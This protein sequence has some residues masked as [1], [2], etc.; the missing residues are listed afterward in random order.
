LLKRT[1]SGI[2]LTL[3]LTSMLTLAFNI[4]PVKTE[5]STII[6]P[7]N[8]PTI[9]EA[10]NNANEGDII[11]VRNGTY[12]ENLVVNKTVTLTGESKTT[13]KI[14]W[15]GI[16]ILITQDSVSLGGFTIQNIN[17]TYAAAILLQN[18][19]QCKI[20][21][22]DIP[23]YSEGITLEGANNNSIVEN[24]IHKASSYAPDWGINV[25]GSNYNNIVG[26]N[27][28]GNWYGIKLLHNSSGNSIIGNSMTENFGHGLSI[29]NSSSNTI[30]ENNITDTW[31][32]GLS[33]TYSSHNSIVENNIMRNYIGIYLRYSSY[34]SIY[35]NNFMNNGHQ[36]DVQGSTSEL[37]DGYPSGGNYWSDY[38]G[39]DE[40]WGA[41]QNLTG[42]DG[43]GDTPY[44]IDANNTDH[45]PLMGEFS[46]FNVTHGV[47]VQVV[48]NSTVSDFEFNGTAI[49]FNV[50]GVNGS[51]GFCNARIPT[52]LF[53]GTLTVFVNG[54]QVKYS[55]V[56]SSNSS[57]SYL[58]FTY[59]L[60]TEQ[61]AIVPEFPDSLILAMFM[62][63][64][65]LTIAIYKK[66]HS[67]S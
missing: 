35:H 20:F 5:P 50:S 46:D 23:N 65:L 30:I 6:V 26:N 37:D 15:K 44:V 52:A 4:Q 17:E 16:P 41:Y 3:L 14:E 19:S 49:L 61:V 38:T 43:I 2:M 36:T 33:V 45:Y 57:I 63:A 58:Y 13:T 53:N 12:Y 51:M 66:R 56:P 28:T 60:S 22:N 54:T 47:D 55:S 27:L 21:G 18:V 25:A 8:Y 31:Y 48:S 62:L 39:V 40:Y 42:S 34:D 67:R 64:T 29:Y 7:D 11:F 24:N 9:Q 1:V 32:G 59:G 10:I